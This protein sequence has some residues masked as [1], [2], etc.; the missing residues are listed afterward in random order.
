MSDSSSFLPTHAALMPLPEASDALPIGT[1][2]GE[3]EVRGVV[4]V[5][6]FG[7]VYRAWEPALEREVALKEYMPVGLV[8]RGPDGHVALRSRTYEQDFALG[9]KSFVNEARLLARFDHPALVKV[10]RFWEMNGTAYMAMPFY[11]ARTL[12]QRRQDMGL[13]AP[14]QDWLMS[15]I[16]PLLGAL[17]EMHRVDVYHRDIAPDNILWCDDNRPVLLDFGAAR[18]ALADRTQSLTAILKPQF[19][20]IEQYAE[21][22]SMRQGPWTDVFALASTCY[23]MLTGRPPVPAT[24]RVLSDELMPLAQLAPPGFSTQVLATLDWAMSVRPEDRPQSVATFWDALHGH[25]KVPVRGAPRPALREARAD[26]AGAFERTIQSAQPTTVKWVG[27]HSSGVARLR[28]TIAGAVRPPHRDEAAQM[29]S[30]LPGLRPA[31]WLLGLAGVAAAVAWIGPWHARDRLAL[32]ADP[33]MQA[34]VAAAPASAAA[35]TASAPIA[36]PA[37]AALPAAR[38]GTSADTPAPPAAASR[39]KA[40]DALARGERDRV[41]VHGAI[42]SASSARRGVVVR[43]SSRHASQLEAC[44][45]NEASDAEACVRRLCDSDPVLRRDAVCAGSTTPVKRW[46]QFWKPGQARP[47]AA[48]AAS[49]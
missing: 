46:W 36:V 45:A 39:A 26:A 13:Q 38:V 16:E 6:G 4:G 27:A 11:N 43:A 21:A 35:A 12:R 14:T 34:A 9:L 2:L 18:H 24:A 48:H 32:G 5:G 7:V 25:L 31:A 47:E 19:A 40:P 3:F 29:P 23:F 20:P 15:M 44:R 33:V 49:S 42:G 10:H 37:S 8:S 17:A 1:P 28:S 30:G 41:A 22:K